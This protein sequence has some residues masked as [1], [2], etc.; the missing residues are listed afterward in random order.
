M[1]KIDQKHRQMYFVG[2]LHKYMMR[3]PLKQKRGCP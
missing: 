3:C 2:Y 1:K